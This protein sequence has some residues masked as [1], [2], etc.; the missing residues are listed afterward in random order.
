MIDGA[1][2]HHSSDC[3]RSARSA[4][5]AVRSTALSNAAPPDNEGH[6]KESTNTLPEKWPESVSADGRGHMQTVRHAIRRRGDRSVDADKER[7][8]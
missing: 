1:P 6:F 5:P 4:A 8:V 3:C 2:R 7:A